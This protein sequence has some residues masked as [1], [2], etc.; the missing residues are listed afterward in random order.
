MQLFGFLARRNTCQGDLKIAWRNTCRGRQMVS[1]ITTCGSKEQF[2]CITWQELVSKRT[3]VSGFIQTI[4]T[5]WKLWIVSWDLLQSLN[6]KVREKNG[7]P[8]DMLGEASD[9]AGPRSNRS[10]ARQAKTAVACSQDCLLVLSFLLHC[11]ICFLFHTTGDGDPIDFHLR[12][13]DEFKTKRHEH[14]QWFWAGRDIAASISIQ[15]TNNLMS[16]R[17]S[18]RPGFPPQGRCFCAY[19]SQVSTLGTFLH[20]YG[21]QIALR[22]LYRGFCI[23]FCC[24][25]NSLCWNRCEEWNDRAF[26]VS[27]DAEVSGRNPQSI[28]RK[29]RGHRGVRFFHL[30]SKTS[31]TLFVEVRADPDWGV[32]DGRSSPP[33]TVPIFYDVLRWHR[34]WSGLRKC[35][36][37]EGQLQRLWWPGEDSENSS[38]PGIAATSFHACFFSILGTRVAIKLTTIGIYDNVTTQYAKTDTFSW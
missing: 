24:F 16:T 34:S 17:K 4:W 10:V 37:V 32:G 31:A 38:A 36:S 3:H 26:D 2:A 8:M 19:C 25:L 29:A 18:R 22:V 11:F 20:S 14:I 1:P 33:E 21:I 9:S 13:G 28:Q 35:S 30:C 12:L 15:M 7:G 27:C 6:Q 5:F 23:C